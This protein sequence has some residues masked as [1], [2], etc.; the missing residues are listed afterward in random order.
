MIGERGGKEENLDGGGREGACYAGVSNVDRH[1]TMDVLLD[2]QSLVSQTDCAAQCNQKDGVHTQPLLPSSSR[3]VTE[4]KTLEFFLLA[5]QCVGPAPYVQSMHRFEP[6]VVTQVRKRR[7]ES[8]SGLFDGTAS[9][10]AFEGGRTPRLCVAAQGRPWNGKLAARCCA[11]GFETGM[12]L[13]AP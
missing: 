7:V 4:F 13:S 1:D 12:E 10:A 2:T 3:S 8:G 6:P 5:R 9:L 11:N